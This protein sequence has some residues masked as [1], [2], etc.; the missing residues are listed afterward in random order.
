MLTVSTDG[1]LR[2]VSTGTALVTARS[3]NGGFQATC[4]VTVKNNSIPE[5]DP[6]PTPDPDP[7]PTPD[8]PVANA[9]ITQDAPRL[10]VAEGCLQVESPRAV[11]VQVFGLSGNV[12]AMRSSAVSHRIA[13]PSG[14]WLVS[15]DA[16]KA[17]KIVVP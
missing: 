8:P 7:D 1:T 3:M 9:D 16:A 6:E 11:T 10:S 12:Q 14:I 4:R 5:P 13:L 15:I 2:A 17:V